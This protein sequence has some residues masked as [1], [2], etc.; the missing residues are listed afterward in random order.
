MTT[1]PV[2]EQL[3]GEI[4]DDLERQVFTVL[5][6]RA[7]EKISRPDL[8]FAIF[9]KYDQQAAMG[10]SLE[11]RKIRRCIEALQRREFP[12]L[13]S[14][15]EAGYVLVADEAELDQYVAELA[16]RK[17][18]LAEKIEALYRAR[19]RMPA[20]RQYRDA[21]KATATQPRLI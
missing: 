21:R 9:R 5:A 7:G 20:I 1:H 13:A 11:H 18:R 10:A 14:S 6:E 17:E 8:V 16:S 4:T 3:L 2:Y 15:G 12:I 19:R